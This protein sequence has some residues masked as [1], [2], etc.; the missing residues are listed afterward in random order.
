MRPIFEKFICCSLWHSTFNELTGWM[1]GKFL[2]G[3]IKAFWISWLSIVIAIS[4]T[5]CNKLADLLRHV[6]GHRSF[7]EVSGHAAVAATVVTHMTRPVQSRHLARKRTVEAICFNIDG[8]GCL[9]PVWTSY[10]QLFPLAVQMRLSSSSGC[11]QPWRLMHVKRMF[12]ETVLI[13]LDGESFSWISIGP[14][15]WIWLLCQR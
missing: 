9:T 3:R 4:Q 5:L 8:I 2:I 7:A 14:V 6:N 15:C 12:E 13:Q 1:G 11:R 10:G